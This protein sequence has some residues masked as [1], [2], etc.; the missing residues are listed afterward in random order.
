MAALPQT[1]ERSRDR[2]PLPYPDVGDIC[3]ETWWTASDVVS[4]WKFV[5]N[6]RLA[7]ADPA[8]ARPDRT[9]AENTDSVFQL[10]KDLAKDDNHP[11]WSFELEKHVDNALVSLVQSSVWQHARNEWCRR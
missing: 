4:Q 6:W 3:W 10:L 9:E 2:F 1:P 11:E 7:P 8:L 5:M